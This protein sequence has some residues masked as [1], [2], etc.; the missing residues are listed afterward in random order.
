[1]VARRSKAATPA[2][3]CGAAGPP[4]PLLPVAGPCIAPRGHAGE[5]HV[6]AAGNRWRRPPRSGPRR[7]R[8]MI[9]GALTD[10]VAPGATVAVDM[11][12]LTPNKIQHLWV[13][14][15]KGD[16]PWPWE[17][18]R[19]PPRGE[20]AALD[21]A[22]QRRLTGPA[23][24]QLIDSAVAGLTL[25]PGEAVHLVLKNVTRRRLRARVAMTF[26]APEDLT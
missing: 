24:T 25:R 26:V 22:G 14:Q 3:T 21:L 16:G 5:W 13:V 2:A 11:A 9:R 23:S 17:P 10:A 20:V 8:L 1:M 18:A 6:D 15:H 12:A 7:N 4:H 19:R